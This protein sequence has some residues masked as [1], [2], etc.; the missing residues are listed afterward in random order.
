MSFNYNKVG[1]RGQQRWLWWLVDSWLMGGMGLLTLLVPE[2]T[3]VDLGG[4]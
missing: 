2:R 1:K 3:Q 4:L